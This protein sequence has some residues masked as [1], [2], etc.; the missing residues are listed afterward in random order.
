MTPM[1]AQHAVVR[2]HRTIPAPPERVYRAWLEP[3]LLRRWL[4]PGSLKVMGVEVDERVGGHYRIR[5]AHADGEVGGFEC[6]L[7]E[8]VP[9]KRIVFRW[10][11]VGPERLAGPVYDSLLT[12][13]LDDAPGGAT[14]L[15]L[16][17]ERLDALQAEMP[18]VAENVGPGWEDV[19]QKLTATIGEDP[20]A[21]N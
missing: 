20:Q 4:A 13:T 7:L 15:T 17:H 10:G 6:E 19:L 16:V 5:H 14:A 18:Y 2:L 3:E 21:D 11:F 12:I 1:T 9:A 8:L